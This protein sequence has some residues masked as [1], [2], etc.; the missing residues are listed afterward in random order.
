MMEKEK[1]EKLSLEIVGPERVFYEIDRADFVM[2]ET[3][4]GE[5]AMLPE[6]TS[7]LANLR[8]GRCVC[9]AGW[10]AFGRWSK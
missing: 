2:A 9:R 6:H 4:D 1:Q 10:N 8:I 3:V 5:L 7:L